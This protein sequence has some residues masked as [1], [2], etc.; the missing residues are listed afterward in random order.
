MAEKIIPRLELTKEEEKRLIYYVENHDEHVGLR[1][2]HLRRHYETVPLEWFKN[3]MLLQVG[4]AVT[5]DRNKELIQERYEICKTL[6][7][8]KAEELYQWLK[9]EGK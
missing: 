3:L 1:P 2:R 6:Y 4:D 8:G 7:E 5:H 9:E